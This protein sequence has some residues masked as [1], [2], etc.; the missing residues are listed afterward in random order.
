MVELYNETTLSILD[1]LGD[2]SH[3]EAM[4]E[5]YIHF[6]FLSLKQIEMRGGLSVRKDKCKCLVDWRDVN[7]VVL[8]D[9]REITI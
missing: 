6:C 7:I 3:T 9:R 4:R 8:C 1:E 2:H 5:I